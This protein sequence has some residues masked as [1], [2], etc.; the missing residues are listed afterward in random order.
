MSV[1]HRHAAFVDSGSA[2]REILW[3]NEL[4]GLWPDRNLGLARRGRETLER[5]DRIK[6]KRGSAGLSGRFFMLRE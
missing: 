2:R 6:A 4:T 1:I 3:I 5:R